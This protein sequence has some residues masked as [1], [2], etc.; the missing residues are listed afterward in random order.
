[1]DDKPN[2]HK[3]KRKVHQ[4]RQKVKLSGGIH[5]VT[6]NIMDG[7]GSRLQI[8]CHEMERHGLDIVLLT[9]T[10]LSGRHTTHSYGYDIIATKVTNQNQ[11]GVAIISRQHKE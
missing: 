1:M 7:R 8:A 5:I 11:G 10:K 9:E 2:H 3:S 6:L 4:D